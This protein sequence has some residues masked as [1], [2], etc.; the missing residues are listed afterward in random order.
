MNAALSCDRPSRGTMCASEF[1][2]LGFATIREPRITSQVTL[3]KGHGVCGTRPSMTSVS[4]VTNFSTT[5]R[6]TMGSRRLIS[7]TT[8]SF[9]LSP[10]QRLGFEPGLRLPRRESPDWPTT[11]SSERVLRNPFEWAKWSPLFGHCLRNSRVSAAAVACPA[12]SGAH[13]G[14]GG[15]AAGD[16]GGGSEDGQVL[17]PQAGG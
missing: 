11:T 4:G 6:R 14:H 12:G 3:G 8:V 9:G 13:P 1:G 16:D 17:Q 10:D 2:T 7:G 5:P 15:L